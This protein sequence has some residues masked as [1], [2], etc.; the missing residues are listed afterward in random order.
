[1][2]DSRIIFISVI[3]HHQQKNYAVELLSAGGRCVC[4]F[5]WKKHQSIE[6]NNTPVRSL[7]V[8]KE[9]FIYLHNCGVVKFRWKS[10]AVETF[11]AQHQST[12]PKHKYQHTYDDDDNILHILILTNVYCSKSITRLRCCFFHHHRHHHDDGPTINILIL[13]RLLDSPQPGKRKVSC[14]CV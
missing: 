13:L 3:H 1:M 2:R 6:S 4:V 10:L 8:T 5:V 14:E 11:P 9:Q 12:R 7:C